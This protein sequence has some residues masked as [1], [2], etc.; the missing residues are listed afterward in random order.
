MKFTKSIEQL[1]KAEKVIPLGSQT[2]SKSRIQYPQGSAP[3][4]A[5]RAKGA[6]LWDID[7][8]RFVDVV[9]NLASVTVGY[10]DSGQNR[11]IR[12]ALRNSAGMSLPSPLETEVAEKIS[13]L[14][15]TAELMRFA[16]NGTDATSAAIR[17]ARAYTG[18][19]MVAV[20]GYHGWQDWYIGT[21][22]RDKGV[23]QNVKNLTLTFR[24]NDLQSL[25]D[26]FAQYDKEIACV[27][28]EPMNRN[29]P[30]KEFLN[31][32]IKLCEDN[33]SICVFDETIT[34]FRFAAGG[35][36]EHFGVLPHLSTFGKGIANGFPISVVAGRREIMKEMENI[37]FSGTF[38][39]EL[40]SLTAANFILDLHIK[41]LITPG[42]LEIGKTIQS[43]LEQMTLRHNLKEI[44]DLSG[45]PSWIFF[46]WKPSD[47]FSADEI[48]TYFLQEIYSRGLLMLG[49]INVSLSHNAKVTRQMLEIFD[50]SLS[51]VSR[52]I[53]L[54]N[55]RGLLKSKPLIP[56]M[57]IR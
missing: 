25:R 31:S 17:L 44:L 37:F 47:T 53:E 23:P 34:G 43:E 35:A 49:T 39:G 36:Q 1:K 2:F 55:L 48:K 51:L 33:G 29:Y 30:D 16:K 54:Q 4:F 12:R 11:A 32:V 28:L 21:T 10:A 3:L 14:V 50:E 15:S 52:A 46:N 56:V 20:C 40:I 45:H 22:S 26:L 41:N 13:S 27:I 9:S 38:G 8:N 18:R 42:L 24:Y 6:Y 7:G 5:V 57:Q 19:E